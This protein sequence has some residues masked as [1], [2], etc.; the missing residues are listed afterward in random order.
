MERLK[1]IGSWIIEETIFWG[2]V[3]G[4]VIG[5][6]RTKYTDIIEKRRREIEKEQ[7]LENKR[8]LYQRLNE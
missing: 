8:R 5:V 6:N 1:S 7:Q 2:E 3:I 4:E